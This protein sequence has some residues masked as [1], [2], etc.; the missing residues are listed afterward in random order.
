MQS[1]NPN[2]FQAAA[3]PGTGQVG[4]APPV[5]ADEHRDSPPSLDHACSPAR[6]PEHLLP[7]S[8][9][10][11]L[12]THP[13]SS[14]RATM[15]PTPKGP[16]DY[17]LV[18]KHPSW[19]LP[20][21]NDKRTRTGAEYQAYFTNFTADVKARGVQQ[22]VIAVAE[23]EVA[24]VVD[25]ETRREA[26]L[27]AGCDSIPI[28]VYQRELSGAELVIAQLQANAQRR[29][30]T[31]LELAAVYQELMRLNNWSQAE[32]ARA[33]YV[34]PAQV[35]KTLAI[36]TKL[37][38][39]A[40]ELVAA[41]NLVPRAA[42]AISRLPLQQQADLASK[43]A[44]LPMAAEVVESKVAALLGNRTGRTKP[45]K[46][47]FGGVAMTIKGNGV[48]ALRALHAKLAE[49]LKKLEREGW[50]DDLL[51]GLLK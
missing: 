51:P 49:V 40:Q 46:L 11:R 17:I 30:F 38:P 8:S 5:I 22:P 41:G 6:Q 25:G 19:L 31:P 16:V 4:I 18:H 14:I 23:G 20:V 27:L 2:G 48:D 47:S 39:E 42:Y 37:C 3:H 13:A 50:G 29:D 45:L 21:L 32:L 36:S 34:C 24:R 26:A 1:D 12:R 44:S 7:V 43:A 33:I 35:A 28:L 15:D 10:E 9:I